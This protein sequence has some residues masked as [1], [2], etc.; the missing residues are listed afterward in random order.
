MLVVW[1]VAGGVRAAEASNLDQ[2]GRMEKSRNF[3]GLFVMG[4]TARPKCT[5]RATHHMHASPKRIKLCPIPMLTP[6]KFWSGQ[7][8]QVVEIFGRKSPNRTKKS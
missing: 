7:G 1:N 3:T 6:G 4:A 5:Y 2:A 8:P